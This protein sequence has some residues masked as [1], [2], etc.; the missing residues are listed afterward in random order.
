MKWPW[1]SRRAYDDVVDERNQ[2]RAR[3]A[4]LTSQIVGMSRRDR[5][6]SE[7]QPKARAKPEPEEIPA[8]I[9]EIIQRWGAPA[10]QMTFRARA[11]QLHRQMKGWKGVREKLE[12]EA[13]PSEEQIVLEP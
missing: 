12:F 2:L 7:I 5:G 13:G 6:M 10:T 1:V 4:D 8:D 9:E 3:V 11:R